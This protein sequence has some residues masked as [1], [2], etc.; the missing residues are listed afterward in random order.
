MATLRNPTVFWKIFGTVALTLLAVTV[1]QVLYF[2]G[3]QIRQLE[4]A[5][6]HKA[7][8]FASVLSQDITSAMDFADPKAAAESLGAIQQDPDFA[9]A[10]LWDE[11]GR[12]IASKGIAPEALGKLDSTMVPAAVTTVTASLLQLK[13]PL[14]SKSGLRAVLL[15]ALSR[16]NI[17]EESHAI[18]KTALLAGLVVLGLSMALVS[19]MTRRI[20]RT[21]VLTTTQ[22][23]VTT[24]ELLAATARQVAGVQE[25][26]AAVVET[27]TTVGQVKQTSEHARDRAKEVAE[28]AYRSG[29]IGRA[30]QQAVEEMV[31]VLTRAKEQVDSIVR[32]ILALAVQTNAIGEIIA[33][34]TDIAEQTH[35]LA[36]NAAIEASRAG[37]H[38]KGFSVVA[39]E[40]TALADA[41]KKSTSRVR[42]ILG[43]IQEAAGKT[44]VA[45]QEGTRS[46]GEATNAAARTGQTISELSAAI[47]LSAQLAAQIE[48]A[49][50]QQVAGIAQVQQAIGQIDSVVQQTARSASQSEKA[51]QALN[52]LGA[53]LKLL[54]S[55]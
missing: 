28:S 55:G 9:F 45:A 37:E 47:A 25:Q 29:E 46:M 23:A 5:L 48:S 15:I 2:P 52:T 34:V 3:Q 50:M 49:S 22:L 38:G 42:Q 12:V 20:T 43:E 11:K 4:D 33:T 35:L 26:S 6:E 16:T 30:G 14:L 17:D 21:I 36:L 10:V 44:A 7:R 51:V 40:V 24:A 1:F 32:N 8:S 31:G 39:V 41:S 19:F 27:V 13:T 53:Q 18:R 54:V